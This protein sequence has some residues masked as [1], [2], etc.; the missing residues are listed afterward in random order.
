MR[1]HVI[2]VDLMG[3]D[4][5]PL[6]VFEAALDVLTVHP[7]IRFCFFTTSQFVPSVSSPHEVIICRDFVEP[8]SDPMRAVRTQ[9]QSTLC[10]AVDKL[11]ER[12][13]DALVTTA[14]TGALLTKVAMTLPF[15]PGC[16]R[17]A[18]VTEFPGKEKMIAVLDVGASVQARVSQLVQF[19]VLGARYVHEVYGRACPKVA[20]LNIGVEHKKGTL[21]LREAYR[22]LAER[23]DD[24][25]QFVG[26]VEPH[27]VFT[28]DIDVLVTNGFTGNIF[29]KAVEGTAMYIRELLKTISEADTAVCA[30][31]EKKL[32]QRSFHGAF[33]IGVAAPIMK[34]HGFSTK[35]E[36]TQAI[37]S[38]VYRLP[39]N[40]H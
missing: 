15:L 21:E 24:S 22:E 20:L 33:V 2:G 39:H 37:T 6:L 8:S 23:S 28:A 16:D 35:Q 3:G 7:S 9:K 34:C 5:S 26:N 10:V 13:C 14:N 25:F 30:A 18:L 11:H 17:P 12:V 32:Y 38:L 40:N 19:A 4:I 29:L 31:L 1:D 36:I 27:H